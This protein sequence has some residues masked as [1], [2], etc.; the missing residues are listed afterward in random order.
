MASD[1][2]QSKHI[3]ADQ[4]LIDSLSGRDLMQF[5]HYVEPT[6]NSDPIPI[7]TRIL[8]EDNHDIL[9]ILS[10]SEPEN[11]GLNSDE[12]V[13]EALI[14]AASRSSSIL[15]PNIST[16][17]DLCS[18]DD[19][20]DLEESDTVWQDE[21][22][23]SHVLIGDYRV[24]EK[25]KV[26]RLEYVSGL[27]SIYPIHRVPTA[28]IVNLEDPKYNIYDKDGVLHTVDFLIKNK[29]NDS[30]KSS[31]G[32]A[33][34]DV[35]SSATN[36]IRCLVMLSLLL[37]EKPPE[38]GYYAEDTAAT[39]IDVVKK[40][41]CDAIDTQGNKC[42]GV[43][44]LKAKAQGMSRGH[45][46]WIACSGWTKNFKEN[47]RTHS[48][49]DCVEEKLV[50]KLLADEAVNDNGDKDTP[51]CS[52]IVHPK[53]GLKLKYCPHAHI[54]NGHSKAHSRIQR[55]P[56]PASR[57]IYIPDDT[58]IR[59][60]LIIHKDHTPH[61]HPM[62]A[63]TK[64]SLQ[65]KE[66]YRDCVKASG[67][68]GATVSK[69][70]NAN[71]TKFLLNDKTP[72]T[73]DSAL[74][75]KRAKRDLV[76]EVKTKAYPAGL[77]VAGA[78]QLYMNGLTKPLPDR[79]IHGYLTT[80]DGGVVILT[81]VPYLLKLLDDPGVNAFED[82]TTYK[83]VEGEI[84]EWELALYLK[85][86]QRAVTVAR[87]Y[88]NRASADFFEIVFDELQRV[89]ISLTGKPLGL[90]PFIRGGNLLVMNADMEAAQVLGAARSVMK[91]ND[92]EYSGISN[93][94]PATEVVPTFV[95]ICY[96]HSKDAIHDFKGIVTPAQYARLMDFMYIN[97]KERLDEFS[98]FVQDLGIKKIQVTYP[99]SG[100]GQHSCNNNTG[101][102]Q[103]H[104]TNSLT[105]TKLS[106]VEAIESARE[107]DENVAREIAA[108]IN[109]GILTN[110]H[111]EAYH[112]MSR[113]IQRQ[114]TAARKVRESD[115]L[116]QYSK[117]IQAKIADEKESRRESS[118]REKEL[119]DQLKYAKGSTSIN[120]A[121]GAKVIDPSVII[122]A[123]SSGRVKTAKIV[124]ST[125]SLSCAPVASLTESTPPLHSVDAHLAVNAHYQAVEFPSLAG[126]AVP[127]GISVAA[128]A[129]MSQ[130]A[131]GADGSPW[132]M[133][134][135]DFDAFTASS[136][137]MGD[138]PASAFG[139][140]NS[141]A[142]QPFYSSDLTDINAIFAMD[143]SENLL[144][145]AAAHHNSAFG[146]WKPSTVDKPSENSL[147]NPTAFHA[148]T[149]S[150][151]SWE[152]TTVD[153]LLNSS[154]FADANGINDP[155]MDI[156]PHLGG[157]PSPVNQLPALPAFPSISESLSPPQICI[158]AAATSE[159][160]RKRRARQEVDESQPRCTSSRVRTKPTKI[161]KLAVPESQNAGGAKKKP[162][163]K[164]ALPVPALPQTSETKSTDM[165]SNPDGFFDQL[166]L[167]TVTGSRS[168]N[169]PDLD[170]F[171]CAPIPRGLFRCAPMMG[172][173]DQCALTSDF[174]IDDGDVRRSSPSI[175]LL[176]VY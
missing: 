115:E 37:S 62:P 118:A 129:S 164:A 172:G 121:K 143:T 152:P 82:N 91:H 6:I 36:L 150:F 130:L 83:R 141:Y 38:R 89:K 76:R 108:S 79:Y 128:S 80:A 86:I 47:H 92:P 169:A 41:K 15:P 51:P 81:C 163:T 44:M 127:T 12:E 175:G 46:Y 138:L 42:K 162:K 68:V 77:G 24:T 166:R 85:A 7:R 114:A 93:D 111:N 63:L 156:F 54:V 50:V 57:T 53:T 112:R 74:Q 145:N 161:P 11:G 109:T 99:R 60:A 140:P 173:F 23:S 133:S 30:W 25:V 2:G 14:W 95:K 72:A 132:T 19:E 20:P 134:D 65:V 176:L 113:N 135:S 146:S 90:K 1:A 73:F 69:V 149:S 70:D 17:I 87:I 3:S 31:S 142:P 139:L 39:F 84:N 124:S 32:T 131:A 56:C 97:S 61:N 137:T 33:D 100:L 153:E 160:S 71:S 148:S 144:F 8:R 35:Q 167:P 58:S 154:I 106:L 45:Q 34:T 155:M 52:C 119:R 40:K 59:K 104:W 13:S 151:G 75:S 174:G 16:T 10:D 55:H 117:Q 5:R 103:H 26:G 105:G 102:A 125:T 98:K 110:P 29:D 66:T 101:E 171:T 28:L 21:G 78:F 18:D 4:E 116:T 43:P 122:S 48:I 120:R 170:D 168:N 96:R 49:P 22:I 126:P 158:E 136:A 123:S 147:F 9:E 94:T 165:C 67:V 157:T 88:I 64:V 107:V 27:P 159:N